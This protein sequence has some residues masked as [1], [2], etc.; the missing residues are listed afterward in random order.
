MGV[1]YI[2]NY[3]CSP[4]QALTLEGLM[5]RIKGRDRAYTILKLYRDNGD[6]RPPSQM[7]FEMVRRRADGTEETEI[8]VVQDLLDA[9][10]ELLPWESYCA[11]CP[12]NR[13]GLPFG[14]IG[15]INYPVSARGERWLLEQLP[16]NGFPLPYILLQK[17]VRELG[18]SG[19]TGEALRS[20]EGVF[21]ESAEA[22]ERDYSG[23]VVT[24]DQVFEMLFLSGPILPAHGSILLLFFNALPRDLNADMIMQLASPPS[25]AWIDEYIPF[26]HR[27]ERADDETI[28]SLK[29]FF[30]A[31]YIAY[32][33][34]V[35]V[36]LDV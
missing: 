8:I 20:Q 34:G 6:D 13:S 25:Q 22:L 36:L 11:G 2:I 29:E 3:D 18:Y 21:L 26:R 23:F 24:G 32:R 27:L 12:A 1:D 10:E 17:A 14:C 16:N 5:G 33:L 9:A 15:A 7:G 35:A 19:E 28:S 31:L 30:R 4:K